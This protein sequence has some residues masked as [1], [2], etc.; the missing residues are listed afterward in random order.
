MVTGANVTGDEQGA[1]GDLAARL[2]KPLPYMHA[3]ISDEGGVEVRVIG[4]VNAFIAGTGT[5]VDIGKLTDIAYKVTIM[6]EEGDKHL[7][8]GRGLAN[9]MALE[10]LSPDFVRQGSKHYLIGGSLLA[11]LL[12]EAATKQG[13]SGHYFQ[14]LRPQQ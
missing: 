3:Y 4:P 13:I 8:E 11:A 12:H 2:K 14:P 7:E 9:A 5:P 10:L 1:Q 6:T